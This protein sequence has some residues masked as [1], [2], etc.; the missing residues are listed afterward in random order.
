[1]ITGDSEAVARAVADELSVDT[2]FAEVLPEHKDQ[3]VAQLL[4]QVKIGA[5]E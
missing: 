2:Y 3:K 5:R 1:M 4:R